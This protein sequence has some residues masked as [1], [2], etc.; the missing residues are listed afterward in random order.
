M[1]GP[2]DSDYKC[3]LDEKSL[4]KAETELNEDPKNRLGAVETFRQWI[5]QQ[6]HICCP[7]GEL[8][9]RNSAIYL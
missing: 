6:P 3:Q 2:S 4:K 5:E 8:Y 1:A 7:T 9:L